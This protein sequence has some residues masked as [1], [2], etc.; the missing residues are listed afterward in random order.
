MYN[1]L[2]QKEPEKNNKKLYIEKDWLNK[3]IKDIN[4]DLN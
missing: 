4:R 3:F 1:S 2:K